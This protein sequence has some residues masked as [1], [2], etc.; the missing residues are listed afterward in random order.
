METIQ[1]FVRND[2]HDELYIMEIE[3]KAY[4]RMYWFHDDPKS[5]YSNSLSVE[6]DEREQGLRTK[7]QILREQIGI[8][9]G[10]TH[11]FLWVKRNSWMHDWYKRRGYEDFTDYVDDDSSIIW[12]QKELNNGQTIKE[13]SQETE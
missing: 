3:R 7:M 8:E 9:L 11:S 6:N 4:A 2:D 13:N 12:M 10:A 5:V 1:H